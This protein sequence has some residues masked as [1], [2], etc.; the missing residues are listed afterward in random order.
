M[1]TLLGKKEFEAELISEGS[2]GHSDLGNAKNEMRFYNHD[3]HLV[4]EWEANFPNGDQEVEHI[5]LWFND[6]KEL[7]DYDGI[8]GYLPTQAADLIEE[9][10]YKLDKEEWCG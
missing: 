5:G 1:L 8:M 4:I 7:I 9:V 10:G 6:N 2:W 3:G